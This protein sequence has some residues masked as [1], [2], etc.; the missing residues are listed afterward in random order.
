LDPA[1]DNRIGG[2]SNALRSRLSYDTAV[3]GDFSSAFGTDRFDTDTDPCDF[4]ETS[5]NVVAERIR[6]RGESVACCEAKGTEGKG[7]PEIP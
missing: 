1:F 5:P 6:R 2:G 4:W 7:P 3:M